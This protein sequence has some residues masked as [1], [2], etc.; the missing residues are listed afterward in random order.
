MRI[1]AYGA[2]DSNPVTH[3]DVAIET[4]LR[5]LV[6]IETDEAIYR[7]GDGAE[8][9]IEQTVVVLF[10]E[11][12]GHVIRHHCRSIAVTVS[13]AG[14]DQEFTVH[15]AEHVSRVLK[16]A[17]DAFKLDAATSADVALRLPGATT[18]LFAQYPIGAYVPRGTC[19]LVADL[20]HVSRP[21]G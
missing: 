9:D 8:L 1:H 7:V 11:G 4:V 15:P 18:D 12:P 21:Q 2:G 13:Y 5:E 10:G 16:R 3:P 17:V 14:Q 6:I 19:A 20:I